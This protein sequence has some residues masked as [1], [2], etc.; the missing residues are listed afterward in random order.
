MLRVLKWIGLGVVLAVAVLLVIAARRP[1]TFAVSRTRVVAAPAER[2]YP[3]IDDLKAFNTW[4]PFVV[5]QE[6]PL[7]YSG[8]GRGAGAVN[9]FGPGPAG[10]GTLAIT[11]S[12]PPSRARMQ[13][14]MSAPIAARN[15]IVFALA[16]EGSGTRVTWSMTGTTPFIGKVIHT[17]LDMDAMVGGQMETGLAALAKRVEP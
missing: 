9:T 13:L 12:V 14:D 3:L 8:P 4:N 16:P 6:M 11:E 10:A 5:G 17:L 7:A 15:D 1:D 2:I